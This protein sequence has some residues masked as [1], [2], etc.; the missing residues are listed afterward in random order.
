MYS[1]NKAITYT[2]L[3]YVGLII[4]FA[5]VIFS[6]MHIRKNE[7]ALYFFGYQISEVVSGSM[8]PLIMTD[9]LVMTKKVKS[10][11]EIIISTDLNSFE[12]VYVYKDVEGYFGE[13]Q[14]YILHRCIGIDEQGRY[15]FKGDANPIADPIHVEKENII[16]SVQYITKVRFNLSILYLTPIIIMEIFVTVKLDKW[17]KQPK[18]EQKENKMTGWE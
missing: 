3:M 15:I 7:K 2:I 9:E 18:S 1:K 11:D 12:G 6:I 4:G 14:K 5:F 16:A 10:N 8:E 13:E 17:S